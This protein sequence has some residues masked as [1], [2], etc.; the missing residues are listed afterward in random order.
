MSVI[1]ILG[2]SG[3]G[4]SH[5][6]G[7]LNPL[8]TFIFNSAEKNLP[9]QG[10]RNMYKVVK[11]DK[12]EVSYAKS[13]VVNE[14]RIKEITNNIIKIAERRPEIKNIICDDLAYAL[15]ESV[16][17]NRAVKGYDKFVEFAYELE[18][19]IHKTKNLRDDLTIILMNHIEYNLDGNGDRK[20]I[21]KMPAGKF[22]NEKLVPEGLFDTVLYAE[23]AKQ[24]DKNVY[25]FRTQNSGNDTCKSPMGMFPSLRI[26]NDMQYV[27]DSYNAYHNGTKMPE[28]KEI[29]IQEEF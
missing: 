11:T 27:I 10:S 20:I 29:E 26:P 16:L 23:C 7:T 18:Q 25:F 2:E 24:G 8:E 14:K 21:F 6:L 22:A 5:S 17:A 12:G 3:K 15:L 4:K 19:L 9:F 13:N 28:A 1:L